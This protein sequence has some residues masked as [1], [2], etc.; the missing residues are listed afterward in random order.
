MPG[1]AVSPGNFKKHKFLDSTP[2]LLKWK[3]SGWVPAIC[4]FCSPSVTIQSY[5]SIIDCIPY[6]VLFIP[7]THISSACYSVPL[8]PLV[9]TVPCPCPHQLSF[10][11]S[12]RGDSDVANVET[13]CS[14][15][16]FFKQLQYISCRRE[17]RILQPYLR[18]GYS[19]GFQGFS[20]TNNTSIHILFN[21]AVPFLEL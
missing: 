7:V 18:E 11:I 1:W 19:I 12:P 16:F 21:L 3:L 4:S 8:N 14:N 13:F 2:D 20:G 9:S 10:L 17:T 5:S 15:Y 6:A